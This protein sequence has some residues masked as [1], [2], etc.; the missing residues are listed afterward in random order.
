[1]L[2]DLPTDCGHEEGHKG[3]KSTW[4]GYKLHI[5]VADGQIPISC[6]LTSASLHDSQAAFRWRRCRADDLLMDT[7]GT[8][9]QHS[10]SL[11]HVPLID[12]NPRRNKAL[13]VR[14]EARRP[15]MPRLPACRAGSLAY[16][17]RRVRWSQRGSWRRECHCMFGVLASP[18]TSS[19][20]YRRQRPSAPTFHTPL[21]GRRRR[22]S[23]TFTSRRAAGSPE[24]HPVGN[25]GQMGVHQE[26]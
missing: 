4:V 13:A 2:D 22:N 3:Y 8:V 20:P 11:G 21:V 1:M 17:G 10:R 24:R 7:R 9:R 26:N 23:P 15:I 5:D 19:S 12:T 18:S 14:T 6:L 25:P 16:G